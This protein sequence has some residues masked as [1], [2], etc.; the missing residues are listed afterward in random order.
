M[1]GRRGGA[2]LQTEPGLQAGW[3]ISFPRRAELAIPL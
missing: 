2:T 1:N 3:Q